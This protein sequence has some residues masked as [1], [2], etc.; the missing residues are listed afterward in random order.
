MMTPGVSAESRTAGW[1]IFFSDPIRYA[2]GVRLQEALV[3]AHIAGEIPDVIL[4]LQHHP[5]VTKGARGRDDYLVLSPE[6]LHERGIDLEQSSRGGDV[7]Y[8][9]PGQVIM[10]PIIKLGA[11]EADAHGY[12]HN[13]EEV[14]LR[15]A[16]DFGIEA[17][18]RDGMTGGWTAKGKFSAIGVRFRRWVTFHG[19]SVNVDM[20]L[21]GFDTIVPCGLVGQSVVSFES[22]LGDECPSCATV[23]A[24]MLTHFE[25]VCGRRFESYS[26]EEAWPAGFRSVVGGLGGVNLFE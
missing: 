15:T 26:S 21:A 19:M 7:T 22:L 18:R 20:D 8:H 11:C 3:S 5:V 2:A 17:E 24:H 16:T 6:A 14:A 25:A 4:I 1:A 10:Y 23:G 9:A 12:L 13:L